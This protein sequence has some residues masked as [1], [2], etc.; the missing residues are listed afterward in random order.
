MEGFKRCEFEGLIFGL[1]YTW[2][3]F[4]F[5]STSALVNQ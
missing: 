2:K 4:A 1:A 5:F 3:G